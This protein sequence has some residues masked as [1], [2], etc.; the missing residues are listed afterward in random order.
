MRSAN[1]V[2]RAILFST[3]AYLIFVAVMVAAILHRTHGH[4]LY[5]MDD[6]YIHLALAENL[7]R[8]HY[9]INLNEPSSPSSSF[10]WPFL[11][12]PLAGTRF[13]PCVPLLLNVIFGLTCSAILGVLVSRWHF[14]RFR[15]DRKPDLYGEWSWQHG[16]LLVLLLFVA[17]LI[18]LT[19]LGMEHVLQVLLAVC[20]AFGIIEVL[21]GRKFPNWCMAAAIIAPSVRYED[22]SL[23]LA[24]AAVL[25]FTGCRRNAA[26]VFGISLIPLAAFSLFLQGRGLPLLPSSV[27]VKSAAY[28]HR[29][30][31]RHMLSIAKQNLLT[32]LQNAETYPVMALTMLLGV[33]AWQNGRSLRG[34]IAGSAALV[35]ILQLAVG[36]FGW[37]GRYEVYALIFLAVMYLELAGTNRIRY[38]HVVVGLLFCA[39]TFIITTLDSPGAAAEVY[40]QQYQMHRFV[41]EFYHGNFA[42][43]DIG[44]VSYQRNPGTYVLDLIGLASPESARQLDKTPQWLNETVAKHHVPLAMIYPEWFRVP[45]TWTPLG[46]ICLTS[47]R[48]EAGDPCVV[49][50]STEHARDQELRADVMAFAKTL[51]RDTAF[52]LPSPSDAMYVGVTPQ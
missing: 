43:N 16:V 17:N 5:P 34:Y 6:P 20:C 18:G 24:V 28:Y 38:E 21:A 31:F 8:G 39:S 27:M 22:V 25:F 1:P 40:Q 26:I 3:A 12:V 4:L 19:V 2:G 29:S 15:D 42:V 30:P 50:Y 44:R 33:T 23:T 36:H 41:T 47:A 48:I 32:D 9:G 14:Q 35:G 49:F 52:S 45:N 51:P 13:H 46:K 7:A 37:F 10:L 11:L